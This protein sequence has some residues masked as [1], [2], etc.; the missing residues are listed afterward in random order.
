MLVDRIED[1]AGPGNLQQLAQDVY[2]TAESFQPRKTTGIS[3]EAAE[4]T[5]ICSTQAAALSILV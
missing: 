2:C 5:G 3:T 1:C 4:D